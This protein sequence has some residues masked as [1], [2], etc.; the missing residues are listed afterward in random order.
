MSAVASG[1]VA[2]AAPA[3][4]AKSSFYTVSVPTWANSVSFDLSNLV[5]DK[6]FVESYHPFHQFNQDVFSQISGQISNPG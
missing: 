6:M 5:S 3:V 1:V 2:S 4:A